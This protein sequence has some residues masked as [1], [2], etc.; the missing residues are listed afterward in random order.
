MALVL[1]STSQ[2]KQG[3][4]LQDLVLKN[5]NEKGVLEGF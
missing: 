4:Q 2:G 3:A 5:L 1:S